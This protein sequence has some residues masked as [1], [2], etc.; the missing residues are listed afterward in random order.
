MEIF[1]GDF[2]GFLS[3]RTIQTI[4]AQNRGAIHNFGTILKSEIDYF[5]TKIPALKVCIFSAF[6]DDMM[7]YRV[8]H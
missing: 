8:Q 7:P 6:S 2:P 1:E 4:Q 5:P 3:A